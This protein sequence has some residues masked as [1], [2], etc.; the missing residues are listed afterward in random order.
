MLSLKI[1]ALAAERPEGFF[2]HDVVDAFEVSTAAASKSLWRMTR[3]TKALASIEDPAPGAPRQA[4]YFAHEHADTAMA[5]HRAARA[6]R[7]TEPVPKVR[8]SR[9]GPVRQAILEVLLATP[10]GMFTT[11]IAAA[12]G[13]HQDTVSKLVDKLREAG[14]VERFREPCRG[15]STRVRWYAKQHQAA[16]HAE[17]VR[18][19]KK[20]YATGV[21][22]RVK[23]PQ[24]V[25][26]AEPAAPAWSPSTP[27]PKFADRGIG[28]YFPADTWAAKVYA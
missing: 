27:P 17:H 5:A 15:A 2:C 3:R 9:A 21:Q 8:K 4:R 11:Q 13:A 20:G 28:H 26:V 14:L 24:E 1:A 7:T 22:T 16:A 25:A 19:F 23:A 18:Q 10:D 6:A 12:T